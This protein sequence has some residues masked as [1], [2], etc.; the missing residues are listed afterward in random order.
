MQ[1]Q[2]HP[3]DLSPHIDALREAFPEGRFTMTIRCELPETEPGAGDGTAGNL[4]LAGSSPQQAVEY[5]LRAQMEHVERMKEQARQRQ[6]AL[7][8]LHAPVIH[9]PNGGTHK[10]PDAHLI[11]AMAR[12]RDR[13]FV[14]G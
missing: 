8:S 6:Q 7:A 13:G 5:L 11:Q 10:C 9:L 12:D 3:D 14:Q 2:P 4:A 1:N